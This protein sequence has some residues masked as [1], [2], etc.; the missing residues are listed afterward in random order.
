MIV[1]SNKKANAWLTESYVN[2]NFKIHYNILGHF[3]GEWIFSNSFFS[4]FFN[5]GAFSFRRTFVGMT[6][7]LLIFT[8]TIKL[9]TDSFNNLGLKNA[10]WMIV[11]CSYFPIVWSWAVIQN[12]EQ[13]KRVPEFSEFPIKNNMVDIVVSISLI[14]ILVIYLN[15][16]V[17]VS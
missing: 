17:S 9:W 10:A 3:K 2:Q 14:F 1:F 12:L 4:K 11:M 6:V 15:W 5:I 7:T 8:Q 16:L 13:Y